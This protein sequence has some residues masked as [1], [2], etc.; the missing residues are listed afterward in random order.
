MVTES[1]TTSAAN[2]DRAHEYRQEAPDRR[3]LRQSVIQIA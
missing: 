1:L 3:T 2:G